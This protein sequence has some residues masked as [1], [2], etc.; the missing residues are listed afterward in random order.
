[1]VPETDHDQMSGGTGPEELELPQPEA[2]MKE[3]QGRLD[4]GGCEQ[5]LRGEF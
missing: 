5:Q 4:E 1:M 2:L 3:E